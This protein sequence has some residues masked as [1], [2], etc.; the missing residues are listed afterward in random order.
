M[1]PVTNRPPAKP[2]PPPPPPPPRSAPANKKAPAAHP[3]AE[4]ARS[5]GASG[6]RPPVQAK[7]GA[8][9]K[10]G[11]DRKSPS[12]ADQGKLTGQTRPADPGQA[13]KADAQ[14]LSAAKD[15]QS[16]A[17]LLQS[18]LKDGKD[19]AYQKALI[20]DAKPQIQELSKQIWD[21][22]SGFSKDERL[23]ALD[24][25]TRT[26]EGLRPDA[27]KALAAQVAQTLPNR[28]IGDDSDQFGGLIKQSIKDGAGASFS[29]RL[30]SALQSS[31]KTEAAN[32]TAKFVN[33]G[34][35][36]VKKDFDSASK[37]MD[38]K[39]GLLAPAA[40][41]GK[42]L[43][44]KDAAKLAIET[45]KRIGYDDAQKKLEDA[46]A[47][48]ASVLNGADLAARDPA[49]NVC[50]VKNDNG[51]EQQLGVTARNAMSAI[52][53][54]GAS[55]AGSQAIA[56]AVAGEGEG[57]ET[58][59]SH[60]TEYGGQATGFI[61]G[62]R[63]AVISSVGA[64]A[65][66]AAQNDNFTRASKP[67]FNGLNKLGPMFG[68]SE[69][70]MQ[71]FT[72]TLSAFRGGLGADKV[73]AIS[74]TL[75]EE[76]KGIAGN[77]KTPVA[78]SLKALGTSFGIASAYEG[79]KNFGDK[80]LND[81][82]A[83]ITSAIGTGKES[84]AMLA[85]ATTKFLGQYS[86]TLATAGKATEGALAS[87]GKALNPAL[88]LV[89]AVTSAVSAY[90]EFK[91][92][93]VVA[94]V[95]D[96]I[97]A[98]GSGI[99]GVTEAIPGVDLLGQ[100]VGDALS[101][102]GQ[103]IKLVG[104]LFS[105]PP[106]PFKGTKDGIKQGFKDLGFSDDTASQ[107]SELHGDKK[108]TF[109]SYLSQVAKQAGVKPEALTYSMRSWSSDQVRRFLDVARLSF[110]TDSGNDNRF[111]NA[112]SVIG[113]GLAGR[114][115]DGQ[116]TYLQRSGKDGQPVYNRDVLARAATWLYSSGLL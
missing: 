72:Q 80:N 85:S 38:Q 104:G 5:T 14:K 64:R 90:N 98:L 61:N 89:S 43:S 73:K 54:L 51:E 11:F 49:M 93:Q 26:T 88:Q 33:Q 60:V 46:S 59:L 76:I 29:V 42:D 115:E 57:K 19:P 83:L 91:N 103:G 2:R 56:D 108:Q 58:F 102:V 9:K 30:A 40:S 20:N 21:K 35:S 77:P 113:D 65:M 112:A 16:R 8:G 69:A 3:Q 1:A 110:D 45:K 52:P 96:S 12:A 92:G 62:V 81:K 22:H 74:N 82:V 86:S 99:A 7:S 107:L 75:N 6:A 95:G 47:K 78:Q 27:Q 13:A 71:R 53:K 66:F 94:G 32:D 25:L 15:P 17:K 100:G 37:E 67:L 34:I 68:A 10:D 41:Y 63:S 116:K 44:P 111:N 114:L 106:D 101:V 50:T 48:M 105:S 39:N 18:Y 79:F 24:T 36:D 97:T 55:K 84:A 109:A 87:V 23:H 31:G 4:G 70:Q 28:T